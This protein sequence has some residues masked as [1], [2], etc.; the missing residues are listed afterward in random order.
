MKIGIGFLIFTA[1][2]VGCGNNKQEQQEEKNFQYQDFTEKFKSATVPFQLS[3]TALINNKDT[4]QIRDKS[5]SSLV[6]DSTKTK[7][8]GKNASVKYV[9]LAKIAVPGAETYYIVKASA[10]SKKSALLFSFNKDHEFGGVFPFLIPDEESATSQVSTIDKAYSISRSVFRKQP[11][12]VIA[13][14]KDVYVYNNDAKAFTLIMTDVLDERS[15]ALVNPIDTLPASQKW[16]GDYTKDNRNI[17]S[18]RDGRKPNSLLVFIHFEKNKG[19]CNGEL[20]GDAEMSGA[21]SAVYRQGGD[22][23]VLQLT[24]S[25]NSVALKELEGC[26]SRRGLECSF[27]G[28]FKRKKTDKDKEK[29][30]AK[31]KKKG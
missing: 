2:V 24:F 29:T 21:N 5:F 1:V 23:C 12:D 11:N 17:V 20:K 15:E 4:A 18:V 6:P 10:G 22:P 19:Q 26:G 14:G 7:L 28:T 9:P 27:D 16:T 31:T 25:A 3:D 8:F 13:E 30:E